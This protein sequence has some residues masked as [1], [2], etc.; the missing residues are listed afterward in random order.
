MGLTIHV[1]V[2]GLGFSSKEFVT[3]FGVRHHLVFNRCESLI[4]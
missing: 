3:P 4:D 2:L 1:I